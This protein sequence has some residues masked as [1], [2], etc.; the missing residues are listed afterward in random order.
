MTTRTR[1][2]N[3]YQEEFDYIFSRKAPRV[4]GAVV[5]SAFIEGQILRLAKLFLEEHGVKFEP[6]K[7][8][9]YRQSLNILETN[10][11]LSPEE[12]KDLEKFWTE[13][14]KAIHGIFKEEMTRDG[15]EKQNR[16]VV[17]LGRPIIKNLDK[18]LYP[19]G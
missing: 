2:P 3:L 7:H 15:W 19:Q 17:E 4:R 14:N 8:Q 11:R 1:K 10:G 13:R 9:A 12:S 18:K 5:A 6:K 16:I